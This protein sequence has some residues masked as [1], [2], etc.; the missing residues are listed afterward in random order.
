MYSM[1]KEWEAMNCKACL[2][3]RWAHNGFDG[4]GK[5][6]AAIDEAECNCEAFTQ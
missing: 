6:A 1:F 2:H 4:T 5:C 3:P